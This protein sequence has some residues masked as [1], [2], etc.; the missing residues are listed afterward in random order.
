MQASSADLQL[1]WDVASGGLPNNNAMGLA[2]LFGV[3]VLVAALT[4]LA[5]R[6]VS[7]IWCVY[8]SVSNP[9]IPDFAAVVIVMGSKR[10][11]FGFWSL[12]T[13]RAIRQSH[14]LVTWCLLRSADV[15]RSGLLSSL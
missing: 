1:F 14:H 2:L 11:I 8:V 10:Y 5:F 13:K 7:S 9:D 12:Q 3:T 4:T 6:N 15:A